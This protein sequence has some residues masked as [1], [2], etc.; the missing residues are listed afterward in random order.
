M[1]FQYLR[2]G[3][4]V[5]ILVVGIAIA[6]FSLFGIIDSRAGSQFIPALE[7]KV[8][9]GNSNVTSVLAGPS[10]GDF[11]GTLSIPRLDRVIP[12]YEGTEESELKRGAGHYIKSVLPGFLDNSVI[13]GHRDSYFSK[14][15]KLKV[16]DSIITKT[17]YGTF[18]YTIK[19]FRI[20][21]PDDRTVIVPT[22]VATLTLTTCYPFNFIGNAPKRFIVTAVLDS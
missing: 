3:G 8:Q 14:F 10:K 22:D 17:S 21:L 2:F 19:S 6:A 12:I 20:V 18:T 16:G 4:S 11:L 7:S 1:K 9:S 13:S 15:D 5:L